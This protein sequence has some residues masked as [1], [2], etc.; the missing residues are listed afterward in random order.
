MTFSD[1]LLLATDPSTVEVFQRRVLCPTDFEG[2][3][4][5]PAEI[6]R[7]SVLSASPTIRDTSPM[8]SNNF[9][10]QGSEASAVLIAKLPYSC[11]SSRHW[12]RLNFR[13][14]CRV[15]L[16]TPFYH[17]RDLFATVDMQNPLQIR[18]KRLNASR[19]FG[20]SDG[21]ADPPAMQTPFQTHARAFRTM[22]EHR[23]ISRSIRTRTP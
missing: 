3:G 23:T 18:A 16:M 10:T 12:A 6:Q 4:N 22:I 11:L 20:C 9:G 15:K 7:Q 5:L 14:Q 2:G 21:L 13:R 19:P 8:L 17:K 1:S